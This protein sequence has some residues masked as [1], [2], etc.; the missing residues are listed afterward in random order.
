[1]K[2]LQCQ[3]SLP[4]DN[5]F[6]TKKWSVVKLT[7][8]KQRGFAAGT[9]SVYVR[10]W[11]LESVDK[12][13]TTNICNRCVET[14]IEK[15]NEAHISKC[16]LFDKWQK[17]LNMTLLPIGLVT[18]AIMLVLGYLTPDAQVNIYM[19]G[20]MSIGILVP[21]F[22]SCFAPHADKPSEDALEEQMHRNHI[23]PF[24]ID[25]AERLDTE[26][27]PLILHPEP[28]MPA[29]PNIHL[30][31]HFLVPHSAL[32]T[33]ETSKKETGWSRIDYYH[34]SA[35]GIENNYDSS[36]QIQNLREFE[37]EHW[38]EF[39]SNPISSLNIIGVFEK[40]I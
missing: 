31:M 6:K 9:G 21:I 26:V 27:R 36:L 8:L 24:R 3:S 4:S 40:R 14:S 12:D 30:E 18:L 28:F 7:K 20:T 16:M 22:F 17:R 33:Y 13:F 10:G 23:E 25:M 11:H 32:S 1:M 29:P 5:D 15:A 35:H 2:C 19:L 37:L 39:L 38:G 34:R